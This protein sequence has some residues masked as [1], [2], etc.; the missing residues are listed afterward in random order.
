MESIEQ[1]FVRVR[2]DA[3]YTSLWAKAK[4]CAAQLKTSLKSLTKGA[5]DP[6][7]VMV[8]LMEM[9]AENSHGEKL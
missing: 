4:G 6:G 8:I 1:V 7:W 3:H 2:F 5:L 9:H